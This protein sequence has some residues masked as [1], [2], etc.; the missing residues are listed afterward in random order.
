LLGC[1]S[2]S[3]NILCNIDMNKTIQW[4]KLNQT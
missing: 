3:Q 1:T 4:K 2:H